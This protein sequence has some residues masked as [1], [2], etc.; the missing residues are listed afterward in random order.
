MENPIEGYTNK[1]IKKVTE[2][3]IEL[4]RQLYIDF[5]QFLEGYSY[6]NRN[7]KGETLYST[8]KYDDMYLVE[9]LFEIYKNR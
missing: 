8:S 4:E 1:E 7:F 5:A 6:R 2:E 9:E 3:F